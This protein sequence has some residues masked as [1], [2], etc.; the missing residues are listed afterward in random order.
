MEKEEYRKEKQLQFKE[1]NLLKADLFKNK[2]KNINHIV[3][4][5]PKVF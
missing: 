4:K 3:L 1:R 2:I 5:K